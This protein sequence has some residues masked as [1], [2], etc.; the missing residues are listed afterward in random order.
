MAKRKSH[1]QD[2]ELLPGLYDEVPAPPQIID[3]L[4]ETGAMRSRSEGY[5][6]ALVFTFKTDDGE[7]FTGMM[8]CDGP[9]TA[10]IATDIMDATMAAR[11]DVHAAAAT[12]QPGQGKSH[13]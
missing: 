13:G 10:S 9:E 11:R 6:P 4:I 2:R 12:Q 8:R 1:P 7:T 3:V 5:L